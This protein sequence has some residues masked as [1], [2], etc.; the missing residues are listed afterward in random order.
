MAQNEFKKE[1][2]GKIKT[3]PSVEPK[4]L[5]SLKR[6]AI[7]TPDEFRIARQRFKWTMLS[8]SS[9]RRACLKTC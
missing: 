9:H 6:E 8:T 1:A 3:M 5:L 2:L 7:E 4:Q